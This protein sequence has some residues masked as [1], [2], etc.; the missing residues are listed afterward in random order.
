MSGVQTGTIKTNIPARMDRLPWSRWHWLVVI[1]LGTVWILDGLEVT[2]VGS[3]ASRLTEK[4]SRHLHHREPDRHRRRC[5][6]RR[7]L[8]RRAVLRL[9]DRPARPQEAVHGHAGGLP[10]G[11]RAD[12]VLD[13][14]DVVLRLPVLHRRRHR[15]RVRRDQLRDRRA[16][17]GAGPRPGRPHHQRLVLA[18]HRVRRGRC[19]SS[20]STR[21]TS[22]RTSAGGSP[23]ASARILGIGILFVRRNVPESPRWLFI[24]GHEN[25]AERIVRDIEG[26]VEE[27]TDERLPK[28]DDERRLPDRPPAQDAS[29]SARSPRPRGSA[30]RSGSCSACRC[31][32]ARRSSTTRC[33]SPTPSCSRRS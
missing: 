13:E 32:S 33:S 16:D 2:I 29:A 24:H 27:S 26:Q 18:R 10:G 1:G 12:R 31:S 15:R 20:C 5:L 22:P 21:T 9:P 19:R 3:I 7:R 8:P 14:P 6:R 25:E 11:H 17:P 4:G 28:A 30:T 23:S